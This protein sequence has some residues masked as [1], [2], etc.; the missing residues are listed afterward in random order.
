MNLYTAVGHRLSTYTNLTALV[1]TRIYATK[2]PQNVSY[3]AVSYQVISALPREHTM[4]ADDD[5]TAARV[6]V[7]AW[8]DNITIKVDTDSLSLS[9]AVSQ[10]IL[11]GTIF[12]FTG[13]GYVKQDIGS[14]LEPWRG[15]FIKPS[16]DCI[17]VLQN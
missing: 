9:D 14:K 16:E 13:A 4:N 11:T 7:S 5:L 8:D 1:S 17:L 12:E 2:L 10:G 3:P 6:Q 15:Y